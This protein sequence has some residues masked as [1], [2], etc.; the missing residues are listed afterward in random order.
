MAVSFLSQ[1]R[2]FNSVGVLAHFMEHTRTL[3]LYPRPVVAF[4]VNSFLHSRAK[5]S[6]FL[7]KFVRTQ[8]IFFLWT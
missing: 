3:R 4:Q 1:V 8:V 5:L 7:R 2:F 6:T